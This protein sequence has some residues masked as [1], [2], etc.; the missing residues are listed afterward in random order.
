MKTQKISG[1]LDKY[2]IGQA[3]KFGGKYEITVREFIQVDGKK[4]E[5]VC[6]P[7]DLKSIVDLALGRHVTLAL[8][9]I[10]DVWYVVGLETEN[11]THTTDT[12]IQL[13]FGSDSAWAGLAVALPFSLGALLTVIGFIGAMLGGGFQML[14]GG[15]LLMVGGVLF[16][17][18]INSLVGLK[19]KHQKIEED[20]KALLSR[21]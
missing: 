18:W 7:D 3:L 8:A 6:W 11:G 4:L 2:S 10:R 15:L 12:D 13:Y 19:E 20:A 17:K 1:R 9:N 16:G 14:I 5:K 21:A